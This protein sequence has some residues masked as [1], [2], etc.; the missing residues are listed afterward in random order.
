MSINPRILVLHFDGL[1]AVDAFSITGFRRS[2]FRAYVLPSLLHG[3]AFLDDASLR[4]LDK[5]MRQWGRRLLSLPAGAPGA[6]VL[7]E[8]RWAPFAMELSKTQANLLGHLSSADPDGIHRS[9][10]ARVFRYALRMPGSWAHDTS[11]K[12]RSA[13]VTLPDAFGVVPGCAPSVL[14]RWTHRRVRPALDASSF[15]MRRAEVIQLESLAI[16]VECHPT[17][18]CCSDFHGSRLPIS[19]VREWTLARCSH[20][21]FLDGRIARHRARSFPCLCGSSDW[22]FI[23]ALRSCPLFH[24]LKSAWL[25]SLQCL[26]HNRVLQFSDEMLMRLLFAPASMRNARASIAAHVTF[27]A[28]ICQTQ[29]SLIDGLEP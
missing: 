22:S 14:E 7:G 29:G 28:G 18:D 17:L 26:G 23:H 25:Q 5:Q 16:F 15:R 13:G 11:N 20:H 4:R 12:L 1:T 2:L 8:L 3:A 19:S 10:A 27:V 6:A 21:P 24:S 9:L